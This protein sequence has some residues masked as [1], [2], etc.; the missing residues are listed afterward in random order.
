MDDGSRGM[1]CGMSLNTT[2]Q[3]IYRAFM[4]GISFEMRNNLDELAD[5]GTRIH[6]LRACG[7]GANSK[8]WLQMQSDIFG[9]PI[10]QLRTSE[11]GTLGCAAICGKALGYFKNLQDGVSVY[12]GIGETYMPNPEKK[13]YY[14]KK[15][16]QYKQ[17]Y[18]AGRLIRNVT[19]ERRN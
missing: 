13:E 3:Q 15:Y 6:K 1:I 18:R 8:V 4:E 12:L 7:G 16:I 17:M 11:A 14:N 19:G 10:E 5:K 9:I 2:L